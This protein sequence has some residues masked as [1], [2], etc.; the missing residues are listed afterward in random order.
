MKIAYYFLL[1]AL[2][3]LGNAIGNPGVLITVPFPLSP[4]I[5]EIPLPV[6]I[7]NIVINNL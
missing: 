5:V 2:C 6:G 7:D 1:L 4:P 3:C